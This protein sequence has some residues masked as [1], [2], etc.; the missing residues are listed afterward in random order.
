MGGLTGGPQTYTG[1]DMATSHKHLNIDPDQWASFMEDLGDI[2]LEF[3]LPKDDVKDLTAIVTS[4]MDD[5]VCSDGERAPENPGKPKHQGDSLY[6]RIGGVYPLALFAD[7][8]VDAML[9]DRRIQ[10]PLDGVRRAEPSLKYLF[11]E[12][13]CYISGGP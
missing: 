2:C 1:R 10:V 11:T 13:C 12:L 5:C 3:G 7:R 4:M 8:L 9:T 6:A